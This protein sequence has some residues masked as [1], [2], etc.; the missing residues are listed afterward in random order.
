MLVPPAVR[1]LLPVLQWRGQARPPPRPALADG[2]AE[3][4]RSAQA[5]QAMA[6]AIAVGL[7]CPSLLAVQ[8]IGNSRFA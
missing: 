8:G 1:L 7:A 2:E 4:E 3:A 6:D 5:T